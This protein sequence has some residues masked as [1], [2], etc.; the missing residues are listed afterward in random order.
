VAGGTLSLGVWALMPKCP[1][2]VAAYV[3]VWTGLGLSLSAA[4]WLRGSLLLASAALLG[5]L[6]ARRLA[7]R[8]SAG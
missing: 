7:R 3:T 5:Y 8:Y 1:A 2:C 4:A 6:L